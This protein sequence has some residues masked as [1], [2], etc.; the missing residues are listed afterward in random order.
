[1]PA[2]YKIISVSSGKVLDIPASSIQFDGT[3]IDQST[4]TGNLN[5]LWSLDPQGG[6]ESGLFA[7]VSRASG[8]ALDIAG[9]TQ[10]GAPVMQYGSYSS[11]GRP[12]GQHWQIRPG[13]APGSGIFV[14][15]SVSSG[16]VLDVPAFST[17]DGTTI[18]QWDLNGGDNQ[19]WQLVL[20]DPGP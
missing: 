1:M 7:I 2:L 17:Q 8:K 18:D 5:Q 6:A 9:A 19:H 3:K 14:I 20:V 4:A 12:P 10:N 13:G 15:M 16:K 11:S